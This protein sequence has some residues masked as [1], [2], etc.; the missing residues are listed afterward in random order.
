MPETLG[1]LLRAVVVK[2]R[3][4]IGRDVVCFPSFDLPPFHHLDELSVTEQRNGRRRWPVT[5]EIF[6]A[7]PSR[8]FAVVSCKDGDGLVG[9]DV[10]LEGHRDGRTRHSACTSPPGMH[11]HPPRPLFFPH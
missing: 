6:L 9:L 2:C 1:W 3:A 10:L 8:R 5:D 11:Y 7:N 4:Q